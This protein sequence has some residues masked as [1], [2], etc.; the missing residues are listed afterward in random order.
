[1]KKMV[2]VEIDVNAD[3]LVV[4]VERERQSLPVATVG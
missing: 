1:M 4:A 3:E 2:L